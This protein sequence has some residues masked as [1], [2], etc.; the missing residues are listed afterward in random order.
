LWRGICHNLFS[1]VDDV[2]NI[3][4]RIN[5]LC[6]DGIKSGVTIKWSYVVHSF[7]VVSGMVCSRSAGSRW[8]KRTL[9]LDHKEWID[10][11]ISDHDWENAQTPFCVTKIEM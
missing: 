10:N 9:V 5:F 6:A 7:N 3:E 1:L 4:E 8:P 2:L 11:Q